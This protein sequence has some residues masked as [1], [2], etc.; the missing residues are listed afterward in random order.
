NDLAFG[1]LAETNLEIV[2]QA[3]VKKM[4]SI[5]PHCVRTIG[6]D[7]GDAWRE[8]G[9]T[10]AIEHHSEFLARYAHLLPA[11]ETGRRVVFHDPCYLGRYRGIYDAPREVIAR[12]A[13]VVDPP[14]ARERSFC[15]GAGGGLVFLGEETGQ[16]V[17]ETRA[18]ELAATGADTIGAA[19]P[20]CNSMFRD[21]LAAMP[22]AQAPRLL[23]IAEIA[24]EQLKP[25][26]G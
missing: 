15:C 10:V 2:K 16:R 22:P 9:G 26:P 20:F 14:R 25:P 5:C 11:N 7:W 13:T 1:Q 3:G 19:C 24:A 23:D 12:S 6:Q 4:V 18:K 8:A 17:N 21:A